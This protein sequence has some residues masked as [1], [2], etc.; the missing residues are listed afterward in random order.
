M[1]QPVL[2]LLA[3]QAQLHHM[4]SLYLGTDFAD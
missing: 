3:G 1:P 2:V 4:T